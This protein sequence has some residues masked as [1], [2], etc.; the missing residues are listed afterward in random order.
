[1]LTANASTRSDLMSR[2][3]RSTAV[4]GGGPGLIASHATCVLESTR[5]HATR[6]ARCRQRDRVHP[7]LHRHRRQR[8]QHGDHQ[9][10]PPDRRRCWPTETLPH[11]RIQ[12]RVSQTSV[13]TR[14]VTAPH[15]EAAHGRS[16]STA[17]MY[18]PRSSTSVGGAVGCSRR[19]GRRT[20]SAPARRRSAPSSAPPSRPAS[21]RRRRG[22]RRRRPRVDR[23]AAPTGWPPRSSPSGASTR[24]RQ[25]AFVHTRA[26]T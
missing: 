8:Q 1:M 25:N 18:W 13:Q 23:R 22:R 16:P 14:S 6:I 2:W 15:P 11:N 17:V 4:S 20:P 26:T 9:R 21:G 19:S 5:Y 7:S 12:T 24:A 10:R 3:A